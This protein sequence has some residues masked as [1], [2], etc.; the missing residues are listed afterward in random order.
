MQSDKEAYRILESMR[1]EWKVSGLKLVR[2]GYNEKQGS[3]AVSYER[4]W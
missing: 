3:Q 2:S 4:L 1:I